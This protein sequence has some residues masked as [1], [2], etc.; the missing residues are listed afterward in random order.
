M[1]FEVNKLSVAAGRKIHIRVS[2]ILAKIASFLELIFRK[3][4]RREPVSG[5]I[6]MESLNASAAGYCPHRTSTRMTFSQK[7]AVMTS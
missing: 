2:E 4:F 1:M 5:L 3:P 7:S 6:H